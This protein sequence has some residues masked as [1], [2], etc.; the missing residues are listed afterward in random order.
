MLEIFTLTGIG[1]ISRIIPHLPNM[2]SVGAVALFSGSRY[3]LKKGVIIVLSTMLMTDIVRGLHP[4][5]WATYG[6]LFLTVLIGTVIH[7]SRTF[8]KTTTAMLAS[9]LVFYLLTNFAVWAMPGSMY[10]KTAEGLIS[11]YVLALPF[12]RNS[13]V[14]DLIYGTSLFI[15]YDAAM[16]FIR[17]ITGKIAYR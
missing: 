3:G 14:G 12:F 15:G 16:R 10:P 11:C 5:M 9:S 2:T 4:V 6:S 8:Y 13:L 17:N 1:V 7:K